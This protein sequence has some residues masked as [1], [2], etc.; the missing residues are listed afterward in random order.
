MKNKNLGDMPDEMILPYPL[1]STVAP[2]GGHSAQ[3]RT[4]LEA[5]QRARRKELI[6]IQEHLLLV[7]PGAGWQVAYIPRFALNFWHLTMLEFSITAV[8]A[9]GV[10]LFWAS[11]V[12]G[13]A[14]Q[15][16]SPWHA[17]LALNAYRQIP[18]V[19]NPLTAL[20]SGDYLYCYADAACTVSGEIVGWESPEQWAVDL[21]IR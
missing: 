8:G 10:S 1:Q 18:W 11:G 20:Q 14:A 2:D 7:F 16:V 15:F 17:G 13:G 4:P 9:G 19:V 21:P 12:P 6:R 5:N 3:T